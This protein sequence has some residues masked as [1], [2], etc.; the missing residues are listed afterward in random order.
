MIVVN[1]ALKKEEIKAALAELDDPS[2][3]FSKEQGLQ[4]YF[5]T[6]ADDLEEAAATAKSAIKDKI[7]KGIMFS[8]N[9]A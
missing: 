1:A 6:D 3:S 5:E 7:G 2:F 8:V 4:L 9:P